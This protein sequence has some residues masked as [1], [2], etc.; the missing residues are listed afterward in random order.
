MEVDRA[1]LLSTGLTALKAM[2]SHALLASEIGVTFKEES[3][4]DAGGLRRAQAAGPTC[5][6]A[7]IE[8]EKNDSSSVCFPCRLLFFLF[9]FSFK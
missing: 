1:D 4:V 7:E 8:M 2:D 9:L 6:W 3:G 5:F